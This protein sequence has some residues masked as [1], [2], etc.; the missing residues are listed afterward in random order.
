MGKIKRLVKMIQLQ[1][2]VKIL[3]ARM[4]A[5]F[6]DPCAQGRKQQSSWQQMPIKNSRQLHHLMSQFATIRFRNLT[7]HTKITQTHCE[8]AN[9]RGFAY[10]SAA[11]IVDPRLMERLSFIDTIKTNQI[12]I[13]TTKEDKG[14]TRDKRER[15]QSLGF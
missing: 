5:I 6:D 4:A 15:F 2:Q 13:N 11:T 9:G 12:N 8:W 10:K 1:K 7:L 3:R 14:I